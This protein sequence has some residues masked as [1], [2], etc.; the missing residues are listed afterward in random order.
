MIP[1]RGDTFE[2]PQ[3]G[4]QVQVLKSAHISPLI[5]KGSLQCVC[6]VTLVLLQSGSESVE[7]THNA[8][9]TSQ[10]PTPVEIEA[11]PTSQSNWGR[12]CSAVRPR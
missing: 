3:C 1:H 7:V 6:G 4:F 12:S 5:A 8:M 2:C 11:L 10:P 9:I